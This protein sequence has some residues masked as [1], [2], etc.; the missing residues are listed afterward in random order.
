MAMPNCEGDHASKSIVP[1]GEKIGPKE[2]I[3]YG[4]FLDGM[5]NAVL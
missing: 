5:A 3:A 1:D 4:T 2:A